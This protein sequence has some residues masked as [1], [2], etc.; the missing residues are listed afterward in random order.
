M[1]V[2]DEVL[3]DQVKNGSKNHIGKW[4]THLT[5]RSSL[6]H[7]SDFFSDKLFY[8]LTQD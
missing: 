8:D 4:F 1:S 7:A 2:S 3:P 5:L 6:F